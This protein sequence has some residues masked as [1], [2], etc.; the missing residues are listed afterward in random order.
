MTG[1][2]TCALPISAVV[3]G[4]SGEKAPALKV[5]DTIVRV[6]PR[7]FRPAE[8]ETL[9]GNPGKALKKLGWSAEIDL[10][11]LCAEMIGEDFMVARQNAFLKENGYCILPLPQE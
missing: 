6:D 2:Q 10:A 3:E 9:L 7:Y 1:V 5:G 4:L 11:E 8:V